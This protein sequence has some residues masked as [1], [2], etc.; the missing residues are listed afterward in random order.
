MQRRNTKQRQTVLE[1]V[2]K[3][4]GH[5]TADEIYTAVH[6]EDEHISRGTVYRN[7]QLLADDAQIRRIKMPNASDCYE[8][9]L[10]NH[11]H[12]ICRSCGKIVDVGP[13]H[14]SIDKKVAAMSGYSEIKHSFLFSG[15]CPSCQ[16]KA[17]KKVK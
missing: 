12:L 2:Q 8:R 9:N 4:C 14:M 1:A 11:D 15:I 10:K 7:L 16:K 6:K 13:I 17:A 5:M 3:K